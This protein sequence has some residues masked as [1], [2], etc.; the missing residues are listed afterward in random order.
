M[1]SLPDTH[2]SKTPKH[3]IYIYIWNSRSLVRTQLTVG[4]S[5]HTLVLLGSTRKQ[6]GTGFNASN[7]KIEAGKSLQVQTQPGLSGQAGLH[8]LRNPVLKNQKNS[9]K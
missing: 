5:T 2:A 3:R 6:T 9:E 4:S 7:G 1:I 8:T